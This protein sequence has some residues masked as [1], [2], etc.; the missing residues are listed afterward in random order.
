MDLP[1]WGSVSMSLNGNDIS[2]TSAIITGDYSSKGAVWDKKLYTDGNDS[3]FYCCIGEEHDPSVTNHY[4]FTYDPTTKTLNIEW[5]KPEVSADGF[6]YVI[7]Q[8]IDKSTI[9]VVENNDGTY[10]LTFTTTGNWAVIDLY[11]NGELVTWDNVSASGATCQ[12]HNH[13]N[14]AT[15]VL[16]YGSD[17]GLGWCVYDNDGTAG[18]QTYTIVYN[19]TTKTMVVSYN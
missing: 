4:K 12:S 14:G 7:E 6:K 16:Y 15:N 3:T 2:T 17:S 11:Y 1:I 18:G 19:P 10:T 13:I 9:D 5:V 8:N